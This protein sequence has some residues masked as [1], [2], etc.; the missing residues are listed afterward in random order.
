MAGWFI[1]QAT[2]S[3]STPLEFRLPTAALLAK[4]R[5][6]KSRVCVTNSDGLILDCTKEFKVKFPQ[7]KKQK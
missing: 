7:L 2:G 4:Q 5:K 3:E 6:L 1:E